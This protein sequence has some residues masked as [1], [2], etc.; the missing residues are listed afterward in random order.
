VARC[1]DEALTYVRDAERVGRASLV[2][3][4]AGAGL[5]LGERRRCG[6]G[7]EQRGGRVDPRAGRL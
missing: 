5:E 1:G 7:A 6:G 2:A 4:T 3:E